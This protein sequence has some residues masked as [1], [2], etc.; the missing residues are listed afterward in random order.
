[1]TD[2]IESYDAYISEFGRR[3]A[4]AGKPGR[5]S[6]A[7]RHRYGL[8]A[9]GAVCLVAA[10]L[11]PPG[12]AAISWAGELVGIGE[13]GG[14]PTSD[15]RPE[16]VSPAS[17]QVV[18]ANGSAPDGTRYEIV[19]YRTDDP[20]AGD[21]ERGSTCIFVDFPAREGTNGGACGDN[22]F[23]GEGR[24]FPYG[25]SGPAEDGVPENPYVS[26]YVKPEVARVTV[27][28]E[29]DHGPPIEAEV[30]RL[31]GQLQQR[32]GADA[33]IGLFLAFLPRDFDVED[34][35]MRG[36]A[37][38]ITAY[39]P[40]GAVLERDSVPP[41]DQGR[42]AS[43]ASEKFTPA[44]QK[45]IDRIPPA[46]R[47]EFEVLDCSTID[48]G[49]GQTDKGGG[50]TT[51]I[52]SKPSAEVKEIAP[53]ITTSDIFNWEGENGER[54]PLLQAECAFLRKAGAKVGSYC[55]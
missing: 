53:N 22:T 9:L 31:D 10:A 28:R 20:V 39:D 15:D 5:P 33:P 17:D 12:Q 25:V 32:I 26:G 11:S 34:L 54:D 29:G 14:P 7:R 42:P 38:E 40:A 48:L 4:V 35:G 43:A 6:Y 13:V 55:D 45:A 3:L 30:A 2:R 49:T 18:I 8:L 23:E 27:R 1:M 16:G 19:V 37:L 24:M 44:Q 52:S 50:P 51:C 21:P 47:I 41:A 46:D 36:E